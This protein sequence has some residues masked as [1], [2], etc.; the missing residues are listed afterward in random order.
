MKIPNILETPEVFER[1]NSSIK[2]DLAS[3][4]TVEDATKCI[5][6]VIEA[7][8]NYDLTLKETLL[9]V[10]QYTDKVIEITKNSNK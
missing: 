4:K 7:F 8:N 9:K 6:E 3:A 5:E 10:E 2:A 1:S